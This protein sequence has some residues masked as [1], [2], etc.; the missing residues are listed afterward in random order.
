MI[1]TLI[2]GLE[3]DCYIFHTL[4]IIVLTDSHIFQMG[5]KH[6][7]V[8]FEVLMGY[9]SRCVFCCRD[10]A[11]WIK[12]TPERVPRLVIGCVDTL[13]FACLCGDS[14]L[15]CVSAFWDS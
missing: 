11:H 4:G 3:H 10:G 8:Q 2:G 5:S 14:S 7:A 15:S 13:F 9:G 6:Q 12:P 1:Y